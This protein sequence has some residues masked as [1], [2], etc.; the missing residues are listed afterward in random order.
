MIPLKFLQKWQ[1]DFSQQMEYKTHTEAC[2]LCAQVLGLQVSQQ[3][4]QAL[5]ANAVRR[6]NAATVGVAIK[7][8]WRLGCWRLGGLGNCGGERLGA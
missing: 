2:Q 1:L 8:V 5:G 4:V 3:F 7:G 6:G